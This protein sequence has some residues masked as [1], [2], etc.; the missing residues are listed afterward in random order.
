MYSPTSSDG[1]PQFGNLD[2]TVNLLQDALKGNIVCMNLQADGAIVHALN[3][4][5]T[6]GTGKF[7]GVALSDGQTGKHIRIRVKGIVD[8]N[9]EGLTGHKTFQSGVPGDPLD[10]A[11]AATLQFGPLTMAFGNFSSS[12]GRACI[13]GDHIICSTSKGGAV[14]ASASTPPGNE[15]PVVVKCYI[16]GLNFLGTQHS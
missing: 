10:F 2:V 12:T 16:D 6:N 3:S 13:A 8:V 15:D 5:T 11:P 7:Y 1:G 14:A 4:V 9:V